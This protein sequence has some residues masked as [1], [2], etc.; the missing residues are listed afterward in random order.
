MR[1][2]VGWRGCSKVWNIWYL[3]FSI[4]KFVFSCDYKQ[5]KKPSKSNFVYKSHRTYW[6]TR[7]NSW[8][9]L[10]PVKVIDALQSIYSYRKTCHWYLKVTEQ[11]SEALA[12]RSL[13]K[14]LVD[15]T[16]S[17]N[18]PNECTVGY[19]TRV[20]SDMKEHRN[21]A[22]SK[23]ICFQKKKRKGILTVDM[24]DS[25]SKI[26]LCFNYRNYLK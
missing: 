14:V 5:R 11:S 7:L 18:E 21:E 1:W 6:V 12:I 26:Q 2:G 13:W 20:L 15:E 9:R 8:A 4:I 19:C 17:C 10:Q 25:H 23:I 22:H 24:D 3:H 16:E